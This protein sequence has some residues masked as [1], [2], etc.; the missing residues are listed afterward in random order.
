MDGKTGCR[1][2]DKKTQ[3]TKNY[4]SQEIVVRDDRQSPEGTRY[5]K[6]LNSMRH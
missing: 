5:I 1:R 6:E 4:K 2:D 3:Y